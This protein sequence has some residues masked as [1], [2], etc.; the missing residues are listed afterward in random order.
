M[1]AQHRKRRHRSLQHQTS[2]PR[3]PLSLRRRL[4][5]RLY[6]R[7]QPSPHS[8]QLRHPS[9]FLLR[10]PWWLPQ[11]RTSPRQSSRPKLR[12]RP[13]P[14]RCPQHWTLRPPHLQSR[15]PWQHRF[16]LQSLPRR[17][18][19]P[20][21]ARTSRQSLKVRVCSGWKPSPARPSQTLPLSRLHH[22][23]RVNARC[24]ASPPTSRWSRLKPDSDSC[25]RP[26]GMRPRGGGRGYH[27]DVLVYLK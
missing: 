20:P 5:P 17:P 14:R 25:N 8:H 23:L 22:V 10:R 1:K 12:S 6:R 21:R 24:V 9:R 3:L 2:Q 15:N 27:R 4:R 19:P 13:S 16:R 26:A 18:R 11:W 7:L